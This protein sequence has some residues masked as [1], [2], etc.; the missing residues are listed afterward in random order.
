MNTESTEEAE[1]SSRDLGTRA[2]LRDQLDRLEVRERGGALS[3]VRGMLGD[4]AEGWGE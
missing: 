3:D 1:R 2:E 4:G